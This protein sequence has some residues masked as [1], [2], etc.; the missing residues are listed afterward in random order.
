MDEG[1]LDL[2]SR[3]S[4]CTLTH[5]ANDKPCHRYFG[6]QGKASCSGRFHAHIQTTCPCSWLAPAGFQTILDFTASYGAF[7]VAGIV[8]DAD[9]FVAQSPIKIAA[10]LFGWYYALQVG[11]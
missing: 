10:L 8:S 6:L 9:P 11:Y 2:G 1:L 5:S 7:Y 4:A 3:K